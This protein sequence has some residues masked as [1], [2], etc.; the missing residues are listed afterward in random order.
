MKKYIEEEKTKDATKEKHVSILC[1]ENTDRK[2]QCGFIVLNKVLECGDSSI[3]KLYIAGVNVL[4]NANATKCFKAIVSV[5]QKPDILYNCVNAII[6]LLSEELLHTQCWVHT[7]N[8]VTNLWADELEK[9]NKCV[10]QSKHV[11][12]NTCQRKQAYISKYCTL[13]I[14]RK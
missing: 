5:I 6:I 2:G 7:V 13:K 10:M 12:M 14:Q 1:K 11:L 9:M 8:L 3:Q 4:R